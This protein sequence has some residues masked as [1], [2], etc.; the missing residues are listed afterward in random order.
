[1][2]LLLL[3]FAV[4]LVLLPQVQ[5]VVI[6]EVLYDAEGS[7]TGKEF[8]ELYNP[9]SSPVNLT[10]WILERGNGA[11]AG[12]WLTEVVFDSVIPENGFFLIG[13]IEVTGADVT[14]TLDLQ[15]GPDAVRLLDPLGAVVDLVGYG[16]TTAFSSTEYF[17]GTPAPEVIP[18]H[19]LERKPGFLDPLAG[20]GQDT[21][22]NAVDF[23]DNPSPEPQNSSEQETSV[24]IVN[25]T[26]TLSPSGSYLP[27]MSVSV[28]LDYSM[29]ANLVGLIIEETNPLGVENE[30]PAK[31]FYNATTGL[32]K[33]LF[34]DKVAVIDGQIVYAFT[35]PA[36]PGTYL[37]SG[38]WSGIDSE[39]TLV[40][41]VVENTVVTVAAAQVSGVVEDIFG[42]P[43]GNATVGL[44]GE[45]SVTDAFGVYSLPAPSIGVYSITATASGF[46]T[47]TESV[48]VDGTTVFDFIGSE[49]LIP[50]ELSDDEMLQAVAIWASGSFD[51]DTLLEVILQWALTP[52]S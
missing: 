39:G 30:T 20:N 29:F 36:V 19:S 46:V 52:D 10:D 23:L 25:V 7:D 1:M 45:T 17:E 27:N 26:R 3:A 4:I 33:W 32:A 50:L 38:E 40:S 41:G 16:N 15:N 8:V 31:D 13:E 11:S 6:S 47:A 43:V 49:S 44:E 34:T 2:K 18:G 22:D 9:S 5:A 24:V 42:I 37:L 14:T 48:T 35:T 12:D 51:D 21:N 28:V